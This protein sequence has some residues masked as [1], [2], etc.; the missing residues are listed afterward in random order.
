MESCGP[1]YRVE[2]TA[3]VAT[4]SNKHWYSVIPCIAL[5]SVDG[6]ADCQVNRSE[7]MAAAQTLLTASQLATTEIGCI[8]LDTWNSEAW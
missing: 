8:K 3:K 6:R 7:T 2:S 4:N 5:N 1:A